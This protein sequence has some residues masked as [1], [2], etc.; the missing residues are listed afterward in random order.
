[1]HTT[2]NKIREHSPC[3][4]EVDTMTFHGK[5]NGGMLRAACIARNARRVKAR[6]NGS[7]GI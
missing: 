6:R 7:G 2:L 5:E 3:A 1:M 4:D